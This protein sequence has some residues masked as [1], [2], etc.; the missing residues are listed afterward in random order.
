MSWVVNWQKFTSCMFQKS[1]NN[2]NNNLPQT[3][4]GHEQIWL[5]R[6]ATIC[7]YLYFV[8]T[9][10]SHYLQLISCLSICTVNEKSYIWS[11]F[12]RIP[13]T[14]LGLQEQW[15]S[16]MDKTRRMSRS[17]WKRQDRKRWRSVP[18]SGSTSQIPTEGKELA[19]WNAV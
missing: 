7:R 15:H 4:I 12:P 11:V 2:H 13:P 19:P 17:R 6:P 5:Q 8:S 14:G 9:D 16:R 1:V 18:S 10:P 3:S